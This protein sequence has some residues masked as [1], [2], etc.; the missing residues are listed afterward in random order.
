MGILA[1]Q[2]LLIFLSRNQFIDTDQAATVEREIN[3]FSHSDNLLAELQSRRW[4]TPYQFKMFLSG[5]HEQLVVGAFRIQDLVGEGGMGMVFKAYQPRLDRTVALK[6][7]RPEILANKPQLLKRF[8]RE[9]RAIAQVVHP[10]IVL[11]YDADESKGSH[12]LAMEYVEGTTLDLMVR[13]D[14][15]LSIRQASDYIRQTALGL[16]HAYERGLIHRDIKPSNLM[17]TQANTGNLRRSSSQIHRQALITPRDRQ[18]LSDSSSNQGG[19]NS[20]GTVKILDLGLARIEDSE[21]GEAITPLTRQGALLGTPDFISPEQARDPRKVDIRSDLYSLGCTFYYILT[22]R[23]P[24]PGTSEMQKLLLHQSEKPTPV[25]EL[26]PHIATTVVTILNKLLEKRPERRYQ[27]P[28]Q[29]ANE[30]EQYL[31]NT[32]PSS[33]SNPEMDVNSTKTGDPDPRANPDYTAPPVPS[34]AISPPLAPPTIATPADVSAA[35]RDID[36]ANISPTLKESSGKIRAAIPS[37]LLKAI[38]DEKDFSSS[39]SINTTLLEEQERVEPIQLFAAHS[40]MVG[41]LAITKNG[42]MIASGGIDGRIRIWI[43]DRNTVREFKSTP[44]SNLEITAVSLH[45]IRQDMVIYGGLQQ[46]AAILR[47]WEWNSKGI[48]QV[49]WLVESEFGNAV[50]AVFL[51]IC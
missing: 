21:T 47:A 46:S 36:Q 40:G 39:T 38:R 44:K 30:L 28:I 34:L 50:Q 22:G 20:W 9:A 35:N 37:A 27:T 10:N 42:N 48:V 25:E 49:H 8:Q 5:N 12:Y 33:A 1:P 2:E 23:P 4:I 51:I 45:P 24:F 18:M 16:Q 6:L 3:H 29:L 13:R 19:M 43:I 7:I 15:S 17:V 11:L 31:L 26:R 41:G 32:R 14:G